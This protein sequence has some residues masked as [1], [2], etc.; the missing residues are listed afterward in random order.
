MQKLAWGIILVILVL[1]VLGVMTGAAEDTYPQMGNNVRSLDIP[2]MEEGDPSWL[3]FFV[4]MIG[5][6]LFLGTRGH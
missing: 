3:L 2:Q 5:C 6:G 1:T 4:F